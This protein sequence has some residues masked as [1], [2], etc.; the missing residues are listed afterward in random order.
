MKGSA[1]KQ[2]P[3]AVLPP[4]DQGPLDFAWFVNGNVPGNPTADSEIAESLPG[5][6]AKISS[7][8]SAFHHCQHF[9][10]GAPVTCYATPF[11]D[12]LAQ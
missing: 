5:S 4:H 2:G 9:V 11:G 10:S 8:G 3:V 7:C 12:A 1:T 6:R